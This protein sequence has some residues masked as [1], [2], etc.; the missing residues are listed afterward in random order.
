MQ[1][2]SAALPFSFLPEHPKRFHSRHFAMW[3]AFAEP[4]ARK[5]FSGVL[6]DVFS[7]SWRTLASLAGYSRLPVSARQAEEEIQGE[8]RAELTSWGELLGMVWR[9]CPDEEPVVYKLF[10]SEVAGWP[11]FR[12][13]RLTDG[14][15]PRVFR[16]EELAFNERAYVLQNSEWDDPDDEWLR[17][18]PQAVNLGTQ[19]QVDNSLL[20]ALPRGYGFN[21]AGSLSF[22]ALGHDEWQ[23]QQLCS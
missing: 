15:T 12:P 23:R 18:R 10:G 22:I 9:L 6:L 16:F 21:S 13:F 3:A 1:K 19:L 17:V 2:P 7:Y 8:L 11:A 5:V 4:E 14:V 20:L